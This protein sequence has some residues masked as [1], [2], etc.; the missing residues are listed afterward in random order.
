LSTAVHNANAGLRK[1]VGL[2]LSREKVDIG[3]GFGYARHRIYNLTR[4]DDSLIL[5]VALAKAS[6]A[7]AK[8]VA[9]NRNE[10][11]E[12]IE[13]PTVFTSKDDPDYKVQRP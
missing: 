11:P 12:P 2:L 6:D 7:S 5:K 13:H 4:P 8:R 9:E 3:S 10:P 1:G